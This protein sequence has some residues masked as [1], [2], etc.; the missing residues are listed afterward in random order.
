MRKSLKIPLSEVCKRL[1]KA[2][3]YTV[4]MNHIAILMHGWQKRRP[5]EAPTF[6]TLSMRK[7]NDGEAWLSQRELTALSSY[8]GY[9]LTG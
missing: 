8:A 9:D 7:K 2:M 3:N 5:D 1:G 4:G 6:S